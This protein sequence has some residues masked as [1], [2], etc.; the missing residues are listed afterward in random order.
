MSVPKNV[1]FIAVDDLRPE[2]SCFGKTKL[3]TPNLDWLS[4]RGLQFNRAYCQIPVCG[5]SRISL[6]TGKRPHTAHRQ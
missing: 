3:H 2:I 6:L 5:P 4:S 1:L